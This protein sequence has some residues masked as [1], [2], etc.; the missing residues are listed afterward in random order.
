MAVSDTGI[1]HSRSTILRSALPVCLGEAVAPAR[2]R[3]PWWVS[4][5]LN[6]FFRVQSR[7]SLLCFPCEQ[8]L[9]PRPPHQK[10]TVKEVKW[11][12]TI[13]KNACCGAGGAE[14]ILWSLNYHFR[15]RLLWLRSP[16]CLL[17]TIL[18]YTADKRTSSN[19]LLHPIGSTPLLL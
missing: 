2:P 7:K 5:P 6:D 16:F 3:G 8:L 10:T 15:L 11:R 12:F 13:K 19:V 1:N 14:I 9:G 17:K 4:T 18:Q